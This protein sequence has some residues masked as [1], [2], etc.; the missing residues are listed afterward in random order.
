MS[1][2]FNKLPHDIMFNLCTMLSIQDVIRLRL[3]SRAWN[4]FSKKRA[5]WI[6]FLRKFWFDYSLE[7]LSC[8]DK[9][10]ARKVKSAYVEYRKGT[11]YTKVDSTF[12][13]DYCANAFEMEMGCVDRLLFL[14]RGPINEDSVRSPIYT[15]ES[16]SQLI[17]WP[18]DKLQRYFVKVFGEEQTSSI[19]I[20]ANF[21]IHQRDALRDSIKVKFPQPLKVINTLAL[22]MEKVDSIRVSTGN[23][24]YLVVNFDS[25]ASKY[26]MTTI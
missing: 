2:D 12:P 20:K 19:M 15:C 8:S 23:P 24:G 1:I 9:T 21:H 4:E 6:A 5:Y 7:E 16:R 25:L 14:T 17:R 22:D 10:F 3:V 18:L 11:H 26:T 13:L